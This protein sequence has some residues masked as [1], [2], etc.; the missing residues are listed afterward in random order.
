MIRHASPSQ[1]RT[2]R[3]RVGK[4]GAPA[5]GAGRI[6]LTHPERVV[7]ARGGRTKRDV[8]EYYRTMM[9]WFLPEIVGRPLSIVRCPDGTAAPCFFQKHHAPGLV[10]TDAVRLDE[11]RG[12][13]DYLVV[14]D[15]DAVLELVQRN[16]IEFHPWGARA[17]DHERA[18][19]MVFD[20]DPD[21]AVD[22][23]DVVDA[24]RRIR[25]LLRDLGLRSFVRTSGGKGLHVVVPLNPGCDWETTRRFS[26]AFSESLV[27]TAP[28]RFVASAGKRFRKGRIF[29]DHLRNARGATSVASFS[30]RARPGATVAMPL[31][32]EELGR[33]DS[34]AHF[35]MDSAPRRVRRLRS[36]PWGDIASLRQSLETA[37]AALA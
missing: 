26:R 18:D 10:H 36:H 4:D 34:A 22:W 13:A 33:I 37:M 31:R 7:F 15:A 2:T 5:A 27:A 6:A 12:A 16:A 35:D 17:D 9:D 32:W 30:L 8:F 3:T 1:R 25:D 14:R 23:A 11:A 28:L 21:A 19:R 24:A 29:I 20:L